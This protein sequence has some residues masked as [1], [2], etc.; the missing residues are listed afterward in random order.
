MDQQ[1]LFVG[2][3][4]FCRIGTCLTFAPGFSSPRIPTRVRLFIAIGMAIAASPPLV[5]DMKSGGVDTAPARLAS[6]I[7]AECGVGAAMGVMARLFFASLETTFTAASM[8]IGLSSAFAPRIDE[9]ETMPELAALVV[10]ST[11]TLFF[12]TNLHWEVLRAIFDS[13]AALPLGAHLAPSFAL[14]RIVETLSFALTTA[15]RLASPFIVFGMVSNFIL[16]LLNKIT[17][18]VAIYFV[19]TPAVMLG[20]IALLPF[21]WPD[22]ATGFVEAFSDWLRRL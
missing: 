2:F 4:V 5:D 14:A 13:Y 22:I 16:A 19:S 1:T 7:L 3:A 8:A 21:V 12:I 15:F 20:G 6:L 9:G 11:T 18:Q 17:P 10:F